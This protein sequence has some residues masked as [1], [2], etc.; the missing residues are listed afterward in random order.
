MNP[1]GLNPVF[2]TIPPTAPHGARSETVGSILSRM[3][4][5]REGVGEGSLAATIAAK[6]AEEAAAKAAAEEV[7]AAPVSATTTEA[8]ADAAPTTESTDTSS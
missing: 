7:A 6:K 8:P 3:G 1:V 5:T 4:I 2:P